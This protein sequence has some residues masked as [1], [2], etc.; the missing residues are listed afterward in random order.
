MI[1]VHA[2][3]HHLSQMYHLI[4]DLQDHIYAA[5]S[6][7]LPFRCKDKVLCNNS[8]TIISLS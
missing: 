4:S 3:R 8:S 7:L 6:A 2:Y 1:P 5:G